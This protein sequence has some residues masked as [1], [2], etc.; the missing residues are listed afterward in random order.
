MTQTQETPKRIMIIGGPGS[1]KSTAAK[2]LGAALGLPVYH[3][4]RDVFWLPGW[5]ERD[6]AD[7]LARVNRIVAEDTWVFEGSNSR[8][9][10]LREARSDLVIWLDTPL[11]LRLIR[12]IRRNILGRGEVRSD[13]A[14]E[15]PERLDMLPGFLWFILTNWQSGQVKAAT[16]YNQSTRPKK[17]FT[18]AAPF[19]TFVET[20]R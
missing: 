9:Y 8:T 2:K 6:K 19:N 15:C 20:F 11:W 7:Q 14:A 3:T 12:V 17:R 10:D 16:F 13:M 1:G 5:V 18:R 4:D